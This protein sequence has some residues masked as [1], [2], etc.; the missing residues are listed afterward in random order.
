[1]KHTFLDYYWQ[2][3][4]AQTVP[5]QPIPQMH[6]DPSLNAHTGGE[7]DTSNQPVETLAEVGKRH[8]PA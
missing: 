8:I 4:L 1:M 7:S 5:V 2:S 3:V 6:S